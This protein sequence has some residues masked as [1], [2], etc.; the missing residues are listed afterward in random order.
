MRAHAQSELAASRDLIT[1]I[2]PIRN[3]IIKSAMPYGGARLVDRV[4]SL[5]CLPDRIEVALPTTREFQHSCV[6][7]WKI[8]VNVPRHRW[9]S[10]PRKT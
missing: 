4:R 8:F 9:N 6:R 1:T 3:T 7:L 2:S 10:R 5:R